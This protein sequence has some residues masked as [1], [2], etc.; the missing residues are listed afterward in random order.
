MSAKT[1]QWHDYPTPKAMDAS[2]IKQAIQQFRWEVP[3]C[4]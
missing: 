2:E 4:G 3:V 1:F